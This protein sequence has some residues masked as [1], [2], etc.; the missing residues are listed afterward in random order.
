VYKR[1]I[2]SFTNPY[3][4]YSHALLNRDNI[5]LLGTLLFVKETSADTVSRNCLKSVTYNSIFEI[6]YAWDFTA[7]EAM[8]PI[9]GFEVLTAVVIKSSIFWDIT[10]CSQ[11]I[12]NR[13]FRGTFRLHLPSRKQKTSSALK[14]EAT[15]S[16]ETSVDFQR[17]ARRYIPEDRILHV[18]LTH[19]ITETYFLIIWV[20]YIFML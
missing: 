4:V 2:N 9:A 7:N 1:S 19:L 12:V 8:F 5:L 11:L 3:P 20:I 15:C 13:R 17:T 16:S 18:I 10:Q 6:A 14:M